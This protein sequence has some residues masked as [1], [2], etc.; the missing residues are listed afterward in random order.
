[1]VFVQV[2]YRLQRLVQHARAQ[3]VFVYF[4]LALQFQLLAVCMCTALA[5]MLNELQEK[6]V[7]TPS[8][9]HSI[10]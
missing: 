10:V 6:K 9:N 4:L 2:D 8:H 3:I 7:L 1:M 5:Q